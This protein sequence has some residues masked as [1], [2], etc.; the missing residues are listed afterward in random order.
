MGKQKRKRWVKHGS[1]LSNPEY[2]R[3]R[4]AVGN[5][6]FKPSGPSAL[7]VETL[8]KHDG[9]DQEGVGQSGPFDAQTFRTWATNFTDCTNIT[10]NCVHKLWNSSSALHKEILALLASLTE[11]IKENGGSGTDAEYFAALMTYMETA[12][13]SES[14]TAGAVLMN[15]S[16]KKVSAAVLKQRFSDVSKRLLEAI[17]K[18]AS[19]EHTSL[20]KSLLMTLAL[21]LKAQDLAAWNLSSTTNAFKPLLHFT[22]SRKPR[23]RKAARQAVKVVLTDLPD[24]TTFHPAAVTTAEFCIAAVKQS[25]K[26]GATDMD[27]LHV[28]NL[29]QDV[30]FTFPHKE[31]KASC[32]T[33]L[34]LM[35][36]NKPVIKAN[37][38]AALHGLFEKRP[39]AKALPADLNSQIINA[40]YDHQPTENDSGIM[41]AWLAVMEQAHLN[42][43]RLNAILCVDHLPRLLAVAMKCLLS[44]HKDVRTSAVRLIN[45]LLRQCVGSERETL[46]EKLQNLRLE[47]LETSLHRVVRVME[48]GL[49]FQ[50]TATWDLVMQLLATVMEVLGKICPELL[51]K[52]LESVAVLRDTTNFGYKG[53]VDVVVGKAVRSMGPG[54][55]LQAVPLRVTG[56][57]DSPDL[58]RSWLLPVLR[59]N[60]SDTQL[61]FF[62]SYF[63]PLATRF[64]QKGKELAGRDQLAAS[65]TYETLELQV[66][67]LLKGFCTR[68]TDLATS[69]KGLAKLLGSVLT[70]R[71]D[72]QMDVM[73]SLRMLI[74]FSREND[75]DK[76]AMSHFAKNYLPILFN[77]FTSDPDNARDGRRL[78]VLETIKVYLT[79]TDSK[80]IY[81]FLDMS[82][83]KMAAAD[84]TAFKKIALIDLGIA[85]V[86]YAD[87]SRLNTLYQLAEENVKASDKTLQKKAYRIL[88]EVCECES[89]TCR[90]FLL[91]NLSRIQQ[92]VL[93]SLSTSAPSTKHPRLRCLTCICQ[94]LAEPN[95]AFIQ[96]VVPEAI[97]CTKGVGERGRAAAY[98]LIVEIGQAM[99][100]WNPDAEEQ[101]VLSQ[102]VNL[103]LAGL[104][105]SPEMISATLLALTRIIYHYR[106]KLSGNTLS[107]VMEVVCLLMSSDRREVVKTALDFIKVFIGAFDRENLC[108]H[109]S[110]MVKGMS[111][112]KNETRRPCH[113][114]MKQ[115]FK[116]LIKKF[117]YEAVM[118]LASQKILVVVQKANSELKQEKKKKENK[119]QQGEDDDDDDAAELVK[120]KPETLEEILQFSEEEEEEGES[121]QSTEKEKARQRRAFIV[122]EDG[123]V[124]DI[125]DKSAAQKVMA[126]KPKSGGESG[127]AKEREAAHGGFKVAPDGRLIITEA[128]DKSRGEKMDSDEEDLD[129][130]LTMIEGGSEKKRRKRLREQAENEEEP[131]KK[132][133]PGGSGIHRPLSKTPEYGSEYRSK[134]GAGDVK[135][136]GKHDPYT[137]VPLEFKNLNKRK[138]AKLKGQFSGLVKGAQK[139]ALKAKSRS[140]RKAAKKAK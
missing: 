138:Q 121:K 111:S 16:V 132:Y 99:I 95:K 44:H 29:L 130:L 82:T 88:E 110:E 53:E 43:S 21:V 56:T 46:A 3:F 32:E 1:C 63:L 60:V 2:K 140:A 18:Y 38:L 54:P 7:T 5:R 76:A 134:K 92:L 101:E 33:L 93:G 39:S 109:L 79:I 48:G 41:P 71:V 28:L 89:D 100:R 34:Q 77:M 112:M 133:K 117:G 80:L 8:Q 66:W 68:P 6:A 105:G 19:N 90:Q 119:G 94:Q 85:M 51:K 10:F 123:D 87:T 45:L 120:Q 102:Y 96:A 70:D 13:S 69:F 83:S 55:V 4:E 36:I 131:Q 86:K 59:E 97:L 57:E 47:G 17:K 84:I 107:S 11:V 64:R 12:E 125:L 115:I 127:S 91:S 137:Y 26:L 78:A 98:Q 15:M 42:L 103:V 81:S 72:L 61:A 114:K 50:Y 74:N 22:L 65:K 135:K 75:G 106:D 14:A 25:G 40:L 113:M 23:V 49:S 27:S 129:D 35:F 67:S 124:L 62:T 20:M 122:E 52:C 31:I 37:G 108:A 58:S 9:E 139:G 24:P 104:S 116:K 118:K 136:A 73:A 128:E 126:S 30:M